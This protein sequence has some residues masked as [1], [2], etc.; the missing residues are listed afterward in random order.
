MKK[1][2]LALQKLLPA[3]MEEL[4]VHFDVI[5][6]WKERDPEAT[7]KERAGDIVGILST[8]NSTGV[9]RNLMAALP[10]LEIVSQFGVGYNNI[11]VA[12][13][14]ERGV[15]VTYTPDILTND[16]ADIALSLTLCVARRIV[17]GD[18]Y[19]RV[20]RWQSGAMPLGTTMTGKKAGIVGLGRIGRAIAK[21]LEAFEVEISYHGRSKKDDVDYPFYEDL[22]EMAAEV[23]ILVL[24]C[25]GGPA[26]EKIV[27]TEVLKALGPHG[28][29]VNIARGS[30]VDEEA[31]LIALR[32]QD[33]AGAGLD[34][35]ADEPN[36]PEALM[37]MDNVVL[38]PHI[39]S[40]TLETRTKMGQLVIQNL[41][42]HFDGKP[43]LTPVED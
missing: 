28:I 2:I 10:N 40:A 16:T 26:T 41:L 5:K 27:N 35:Y 42:S 7:I 33:I 20:G 32:N 29:L 9:S 6:L 21:R 39:G 34:V 12:A 17:E 31:L 30:V 13:A 4:A 15:A 37:K 22:E 19:V 25:S 8:Y 18:M 36:V 23:D 24:A 14:K 11:D 43:L 38:L 3:E 1:T